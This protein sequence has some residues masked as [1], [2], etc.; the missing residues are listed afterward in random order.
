LLL[1]SSFLLLLLPLVG[2]EDDDCA[3]CVGDPP[4]PEPTLANV[5]PNEDGR[6]W[7]YDFVARE[8]SD[9]TLPPDE[10]YTIEDVDSVLA[11]A[12][13]PDATIEAHIW[14]QVFEGEYTTGPGVT[15]QNL[16]GYY[17]KDVE[18]GS[19][20]W[21]PADI[22]PREQRLVWPA[23]MTMA[24]VAARRICC[25]GGLLLEGGPAFVKTEE[26]IATYGEL[27]LQLSWKW[28]EADL[29]PGAGFTLQLVPALADDVF[30]YGEIR[31]V[32]DLST[33]YGD[34][35]NAL[36]VNY[37]IDKGE[38]E[39]LGTGGE[40]T[41]TYHPYTFGRMEFVPEVGPVYTFERSIFPGG[42][43]TQDLGTGG[44]RVFE[45]EYWLI[46]TGMP[47]RE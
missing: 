29:S 14:R 42:D 26:Y 47:E 37:V 38:V 24:D 9:T 19:P 11:E 28:L 16:R 40:P 43:V 25:V 45:Y 17:F 27:D 2:C 8:W 23:Q 33:P 13:S 3:T 46:G 12:A 4:A 5:W 10:V 30:L 32:H 41:S 1:A 39:V 34:F 22:L 15:G 35:E 44:P 31:E 6:G 36:S 18:G 7:T 21:V 20:R